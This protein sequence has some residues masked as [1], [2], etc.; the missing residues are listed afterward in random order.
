[1]KSGLTAQFAVLMALA[2]AGVKL[3]GNLLAESVVGTKNGPAAAGHWQDGIS[4][5]TTPMR[6]QSSAKGPISRSSG[7]TR[8][9]YFFDLVAR[10]GR[11]PYRLIFAKR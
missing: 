6:W 1:M 8:G 11:R 3:R 9:G 7:A 5:A 4:A 10:A 2:R